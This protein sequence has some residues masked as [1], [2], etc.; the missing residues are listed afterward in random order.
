MAGSTSSDGTQ[1]ESPAST[2][3]HGTCDSRAGTSRRHH[4]FSQKTGCL[5][6]GIGVPALQPGACLGLRPDL[7]ERVLC[8]V[9]IAYGTE[10]AEF[11]V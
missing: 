7:R 2:V 5:L 11:L 1:S 9:N 10:T 4:E 8:L 6:V 3:R